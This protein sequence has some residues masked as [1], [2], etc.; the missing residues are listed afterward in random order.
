ML[1]VQPYKEE[2][3]NRVTL[4][5]LGQNSLTEVQIQRNIRHGS[6]SQGLIN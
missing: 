5:S 4:S 3:K 1:Q 2:K 6:Y